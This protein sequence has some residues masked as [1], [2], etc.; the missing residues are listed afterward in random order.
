[1]SLAALFAAREVALQFGPS[2]AV[3]PFFGTA[4]CIGAICG[5][6]LPRRIIRRHL[7]RTPAAHAANSNL[8]GGQSIELEFAASIAGGLTL[9]LAV[10]W[11]IVGGFLSG[12]E[13]YRSLLTQRFF[14]P[15]WLTWALL[16]MP[17]WI[18]VA[19]FAAL[20]TMAT[21]AMQGWHFL[22]AG[23]TARLAS[24]WSVLITGGAIGL[25]IGQHLLPLSSGLFII[26]LLVLFAAAMHAVMRRQVGSHAPP[27]A[28]R[29][30]I[31]VS[32]ITEPLSVVSALS[33][34]TAALF[35]HQ[36]VLGTSGSSRSWL[37][38]D[39]VA[40]A[41]IVGVLVGRTALVWLPARRWHLPATLLLAA[42][43]CGMALRHD[44]AVPA[45]W[46]FS[47]LLIACTASGVT[48]AARRLA[49]LLRRPQA[50]L[51]WLGTTL[52]L[53]SAAGLIVGSIMREPLS[54]RTS[55]TIAALLLT[56]TAALLLIFGTYRRPPR[57]IGLT[58]VSAWLLILAWLGAGSSP[59]P[60]DHTATNS[61]RKELRAVTRAFVRPAG[62]RSITVHVNDCVAG[63]HDSSAWQ[64]DLQG[65]RWDV[66]FVHADKTV[67]P[68][69]L[70]SRQT[71]VSRLS[72]R[73]RH[74][75][76]MG[77]WL[78]IDVAA[79]DLCQSLSRTARS[80]RIPAGLLRV[81]YAQS[82]H[83]V[84]TVGPGVDALRDTANLPAG[85]SGEWLPLTSDAATPPSSGMAAPAL[86]L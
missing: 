16:I 10:L 48:I 39:L 1:M 56:M 70:S 22:A 30:T 61:L 54:P 11:L 67:E 60:V 81:Q 43:I 57:V 7:E 36:L 49:R 13:N 24:I 37:Q 25:I 73:L 5:L 20:A 82:V 85:V 19:A 9:V 47:L 46:S 12:L 71:T 17:I 86:A 2:S 41:I 29:T 58:A 51:T 32:Q 76:R 8:T 79:E 44:A 62:A 59:A 40:L 64:V 77:G 78:V 14:H 65:P 66:I 50:A 69:T 23:G 63:E 42:V 45:P 68:A 84:L 72:A 3:F 80:N 74:A 83:T 15:A 31:R 75:L 6:N 21:I 55:S 28:Q 27:A 26:S 52:A 33:F 18:T 53:A 35:V 38:P 34:V 4:V